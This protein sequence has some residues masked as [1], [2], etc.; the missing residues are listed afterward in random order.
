MA[1]SIKVF[2]SQP[3]NG[4]EEKVLRLEEQ[5]YLRMVKKRL[6]YNNLERVGW[7]NE[8]CGEKG[9]LFYL[10]KSIEAMND[11]DVVV[12]CPGWE[13]ARGCRIEW[14]VARE[15]GKKIVYLG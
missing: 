10:A 1:K 11:A 5:L 2:L 13:Q 9:P 6:G 12:F 14:E 15:Y 3:M 7:V 8:D 4:K